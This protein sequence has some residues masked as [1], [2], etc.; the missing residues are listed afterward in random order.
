MIEVRGLVK[1][2][3]ERRVLR[4]LDF[5]VPV[6]R[7]CGFLG[8]NGSGKSTT[9]DILAGLLG[10]SDGDAKICGYSV[11]TQTREA[12]ALVGYL[13]DNPPLYEE[14]RIR[15]YVEYV[16]RLRGLRGNALKLAVDKVLVDC[17]VTEDQRRVIGHLSKGF[18]QRVA[19]C[20]AIVHNPQ[21]LILDEPTEGLDPSQILHIRNLVRKLA[22]DR[23]VI[24]SSHI[25][26]EVQATCDDVIVINQGSI[27]AQTSL[28]DDA[29]KHGNYVFHLANDL[30]KTQNWFQERDFVANVRTHQDEKN[31]LLVEFN[32]DFWNEKSPDNLAK[33][34]ALLVQNGF[35]VAGFREE[36][37]GIEELFFRSIKSNGAAQK[38]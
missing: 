16:G 22:K 15:D 19:L 9:M 29:A 33:V 36:K 1:C 27:V 10:P 21:V 7:I 4:A 23:T 11:V 32:Q 25:L 30:E 37:L 17:D 8:P 38:M 14:M 3:G 26:S 13:P 12:K 35:L 5:T 6:G 28:A 2:Y 24:M 20:A 31:S 18:K 34:N